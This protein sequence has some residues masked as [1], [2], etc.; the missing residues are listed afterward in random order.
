MIWFIHDVKGLLL[1]VVMLA[2]C[3]IQPV[4]AADHKIVVIADP[5][6]MPASLLTNPNNSDWKTYLDGSRKLIDYSQAL[7]D[8]AVTTISAM[9]DKP[10]L[11]LI[12]G[13]LTK[14]GEKASHNYLIGKLDD[15]KA[16]GIQTLVIPGNHDLG[17]TDAKVYGMT[18]SDAATITLAGFAELYKD[19]GY[20]ST[21]ER[22]ST[23]SLTYACEPIDGLV[24]LGIDS[25][26]EGSL[27]A[28]VLSWVCGKAS[29]ARA[30]GKQVIAMMHHP[31]IPHI[32]GG[33]A[34]M[35]SVSVAHY[36]DVRNSLAD[37]GVS[38]IFTG[39][40]HISDI[41][42]DWNGDKSKTIYDVTT[43][44]LCSYPCD[45]R[46]VTI[47][48]TLTSME[49]AT[50][51]IT[52]TEG[53]SLTDEA[54][55]TGTAKTRLKE[56]MTSIIEAKLTDRGYGS[57]ASMVA[58]L[59]ASAYIFH[60][61]GNENLST[62]ENSAASCLATLQTALSLAKIL[63][64]INDEQ[65]AEF[66]AMAISMLQDYSNYGDVNREDQTNDR[67]L[68]I[69]MPINTSN[70]L[71][72][73]GDANADGIV[74]AADLVE[75]ISVAK[76]NAPSAAFNHTNADMSGDSLITND[77]IDAVAA[78]IMSEESI[79]NCGYK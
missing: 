70:I 28:D 65:S 75:M 16:A 44:S 37:A 26:T 40:S 53:R 41:A 19:Y 74:N 17:T 76:G 24:I 7:F 50:E 6:V 63:G 57:L 38:V 34:F 1:A 2:S 3:C 67:T 55:S 13:D 56:S 69:T 12:V 79:D 47:D 5:H 43:G 77:D 51:S 48:H 18:T 9:E 54:F 21:S 45:Y 8:Q 42:K 64:K 30:A 27:S 46:V 22:E 15:L 20:G 10:E 39:H 52:T 60:A 66:S 32:T 23:S 33:E 25:G 49:I 71:H 72:R 58:P 35:S 68:S 31:L 73:P 62:G 78:L 14:D 36:A 4:S 11:V 59:L 29:E 61:E